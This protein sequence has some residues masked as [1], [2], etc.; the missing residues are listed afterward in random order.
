MMFLINLI[1]GTQDVTIEKHMKQK[2]KDFLLPPIKHN[3]L[4]FQMK[5]NYKIQCMIYLFSC[6]NK[7]AH[8]I[9]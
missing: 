9:I 4:K 1:R 6:Y 7:L 2:G 5:N 3:N 8:R